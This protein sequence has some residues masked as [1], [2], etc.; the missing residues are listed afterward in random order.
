M[1]DKVAIKVGFGTL[2]MI[3]ITLI[4]I[5]WKGGVLM[6]GSGREVVGEFQDIGG[7][8][9]GAEVRFRGYKVGR[10]VKI[11]P[12]ASSIRV[13]VRIKRDVPL[14]SA[15]VM[16]VVFDG[17]V[18][19]KFIA[20]RPGPNPKVLAS[21]NEVL[22]GYASSGLADVVEIGTQNLVHT[23]AILKSFRETVTSQAFT[24]SIQETVFSLSRMVSQLEQFTAALNK[25][26]TAQDLSQTIS[27]L[28]SLTDS[29]QKMVNTVQTQYLNEDMAQ[30]VRNTVKNLSQVTREVKDFTAGS[31]ET[32]P[33]IFRTISTL[34]YKTEAGVNYSA[35]EKLGS[36]TA[37]LDIGSGNQFVRTGLSDR[38]G[39]TQVAIIQHGVKVSDKVAARVGFY[40]SK[41]GVG[42]DY[43]VNDK[44]KVALDVYDMNKA[45]ADLSAR[46]SFSKN[47]DGQ[48]TL[49]ND[50]KGSG[51]MN[52]VE[53]GVVIRP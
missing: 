21:N 24:R 33:S 30:D 46:Y 32:S 53:V 52:N 4:L 10:V 50:T 9:Q 14:P 43:S 45:K 2:I 34:Q 19:E 48:V 15:S 35:T 17:L 8:L 16:R 39:D 29:M 23:E 49:R 44:V 12:G 20:I 38:A 25:P 40:Y 13:Y 31:S 26:E 18:G 36:Y 7:L 5:M 51:S 37:K 27:G 3:V 1:Q 41:P 28:R 42:V 6:S 47:M 11:E 22:V